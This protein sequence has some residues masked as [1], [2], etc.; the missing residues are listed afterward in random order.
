L[1]TLALAVPDMTAAP[2]FK[3]GHVSMSTLLIA[4]VCYP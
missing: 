1:T 3:M 2:K 4:V